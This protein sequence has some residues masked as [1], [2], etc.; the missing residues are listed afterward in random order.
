M[1]THLSS[2]SHIRHLL[3]LMSLITFFVFGCKKEATESINEEIAT[4][5]RFDNSGEGRGNVSPEM[6]L[7]WNEAAV[8]VVSRTLQIQSTPRIPP[9]RESH[10]YATVNIAVHD[11]LNNIVPKYKSYALNGRDK[12]AD[13]DAAVAKAAHDVISFF[14]GKLNPPANSTPQVVQDYIH[15]LLTQSLNS[16][17]DGDAKTKGIALGAAAAQAIIQ[18]R[19]NDGIAN[20]VFAITQGTQAGEYRSTPP[21]TVSG[22]YDSPGWGNVKTFGIKQYT[23]S[24]S[25]SIFF[26]QPGIHCGL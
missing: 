8:Y 12:D 9:F 25:T 3:L 5:A 2:R 1:T 26:D 16:I 17:P 19:T 21:F 15:D 23:V 10:Y 14:F 7:R 24:C 4:N 18:N 11:A 13:P 6:V 22:F 20:A